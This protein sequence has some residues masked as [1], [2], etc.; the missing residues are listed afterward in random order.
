MIRCA[1]STSL[2]KMRSSPAKSIRFLMSSWVRSRNS[3]DLSG[4][5]KSKAWAAHKSS[6]ARMRSRFRITL[7]AFLPPIEPMLTW[8]SCPSEVGMLSA[9]AGK[10]SP[11]FSLTSAAEVYCRIMK[12]ELSPV[13]FISNLGVPSYFPSRER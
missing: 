13:S 1:F 2:L 8:S 9:L 12:P 4:F 10:Q 3:L 5:L 7:R 11:L 6:M